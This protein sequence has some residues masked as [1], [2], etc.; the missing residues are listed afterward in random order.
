MG[1][2]WRQVEAHLYRGNNLQQGSRSIHKGLITKEY[3]NVAK[4]YGILMRKDLEDTRELT[5]CERG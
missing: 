4:N 3:A 2:P 1:W 5:G